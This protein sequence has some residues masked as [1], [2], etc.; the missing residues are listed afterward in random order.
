MSGGCRSNGLHQSLH[1]TLCAK[2]PSIECNRIVNIVLS[3]VNS[4]QNNLRLPMGD[5]E[6]QVS[7]V[8]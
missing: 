8:N 1:C 7:L 6:E 2:R 5:F 3:L 4:I